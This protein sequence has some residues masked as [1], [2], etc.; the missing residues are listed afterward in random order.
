MPT[1]SF[2]RRGS[3][4]VITV[5]NPPVNAMSVG[6]PGAILA[7]LE[8]AK[9]DP[10]VT[11]VVFR[12]GGGGTIAGADIRLFGKPWPAGEPTL[13]DVIVA[14]EASPKPVIAAIKG[15]CLG[16][17]LEI[18]LGCHYRVAAPDA[19][20][21]QPEVKLGFP[22]G[23]GGTQ[24]LP[25]LAGVD[26]ALPIIVEGNPVPARKAHD[27]GILDAII[28]GDLLAGAVAFAEGKVAAGNPHPRA[29]DRKA[30]VKDP[31]V[32]QATRD[33]L[34]KRARGQ[35]APFA[36][37]ECVEAAVT[38]PFDEGVKRE[39]AIFEA[40]MASE[41][42]RAL[43]HVFFAERAIGNVPGVGKDTMPKPI[44]QGGVVGSGTMG[45]GIAM[46]FANAGIPVKLH[47]SN[48]AALERGMA[49][50]RKTY[51]GSVS[52]G[53]LTQDKADKA[54]ALVTPTGDLAALADADIVIE[55]VFEEMPIKLD[56]F[57]ALDKT[58]KK[59]AILASNTSYLDI[60]AIA[61]TIPGREG[62]VLG[63]HFFSPAN[64]MR[65]LEVVR[66]KTASPATLATVLA[67][68]RRMRK[69]AVVAGVCHGF[70]G[71]RMLEGYMREAWFLL[72]EG[73][74]PQDV[75]KAITDFGFP[76][77][78]FAV[79]DLAG[80]DV[81]W[82]KRKAN[83]HL[84]AP[85]KR[86]AAIGDK[87]CEMGRFGQKTGAGFY[88]YE[89]GGRTPIPDPVVDDLIVA[90]AKEKGIKRRAIGAQEII[91]RCLYPLVNEGAR[92][93][94]EGIALRGGDIDIVWINGYGFPA[95][96]GGP[97]FWADSVGLGT[98]LSAIER[99]GR[100]HD[101]W[102]PAPLLGRLAKQGKGFGDLETKEAGDA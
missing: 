97:M 50:I 74:S 24:R 4:G 20:V 98:V 78:P 92:I 81:G 59:G 31:T 47:D 10:A 34:A 55:A 45:T 79:G 53:S 6:V 64:V 28:D 95:W 57:R 101:Y 27:L 87:L 29:R 12:G 84:R 61:D 99:Y 8:D 72:E 22:P 70:I 82:R 73:A 60:D 15:S 1:A 80:L 65:L 102:E 75:D 33:K 17:G 76:M 18:A 86:H 96:R 11:A 35:R 77:G 62:D 16:G 52:R 100:E 5:E 49:T 51:A 88:R 91:E 13:R 48:A 42:S 25:R 21:G 7:R 63:T 37:I 38:L 71:N 19:S 85:N 23:A 32:F 40:C 93:L 39:R 36:C 9:A 68:G 58:C 94:E 56:V 83:A 3:I 46:N 43:R 69:V 44:A 2:E 66:T 14:F 30:V 90:L 54:L 41:E 67:L 89:A 26:A